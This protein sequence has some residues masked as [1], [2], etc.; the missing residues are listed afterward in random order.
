MNSNILHDP[1]FPHGTPGGFTAGCHGAHCPAAMSCR[2][3]YR[4]HSGD[5]SFRKQ[6]DAG[7]PIE[8]ILEAEQE[9]ARIAAEAA[10]QARRRRPGPRAKVKGIDG[11]ATANRYQIIPRAQLRE[12]LDQGLTDRQIADK[13][14]LE[15]RQVTGARVNAGWDRNPDV[16]GGNR[17]SIDVLLPTVAHLDHEAAAKALNRSPDYIKRRRQIAARNLNQALASP[18]LSSSQETT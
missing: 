12:M 18:G 9:Q 15:R 8:V 16:K 4:R 1:K 2:D 11:R 14:G 13:C 7:V 17:T 3:V 6:L 10:K 5:W